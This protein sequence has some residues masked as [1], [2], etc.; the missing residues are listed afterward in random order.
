MPKGPANGSPRPSQNGHWKQN[1]DL[2]LQGPCLSSAMAQ[3]T[4]RDSKGFSGQDCTQHTPEHAGRQLRFLPQRTKTGSLRKPSV[5]TL[6][7]MHPPCRASEE[8]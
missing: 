3:N 8:M 1:S 6:L 2:T 5:H 4:C 7:D